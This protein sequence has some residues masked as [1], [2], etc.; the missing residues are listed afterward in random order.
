MGCNL[1]DLTMSVGSAPSNPHAGVGQAPFCVPK[2][3]WA[4]TNLQGIIY[5][6]TMRI[7]QSGAVTPDIKSRS[8]TSSS[9]CS[10]SPKINGLILPAL[11]RAGFALF[12]ES[13]GGFVEVLGEI[14]L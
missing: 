2:K 14:E 13:A 7:R 10:D 4:K 9:G 8:V 12:G 3:A 11:E 1:P 6:T 5:I